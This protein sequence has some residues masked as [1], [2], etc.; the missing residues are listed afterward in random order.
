VALTFDDG[1]DPVTTPQVLDVLAAHGARATFFML[2][3][4]AARHPHLVARVKAEGHEIGNHSW[5]HPSLATLDKAGLE[6]Q[7]LRTREVLGHHGGP[8]LRPPYG[9]QSLKSFRFAQQHGYRPVCWSVACADWM[10]GDGH[11]LA[12][13]LLA[14]VKPGSIVLLHDHLYTFE[15]PRHRDRSAMLKALDILLSERKDHQFVTV[16]DLLAMGREEKV[17]WLSGPI[18]APVHSIA[19]DEA[20]TPVSQEQEEVVFGMN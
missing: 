14:E 4:L 5:D 20:S 15:D 3:K 9:Y 17:Y 19:S 7:I 18:E 6:Q 2:G 10:E 11:L 13:R 8:L 12:D 16:S 1:P